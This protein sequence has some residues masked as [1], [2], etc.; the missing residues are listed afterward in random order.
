MIL[1][2]ETFADLDTRTLY[3]LLRLRGD[4]FVVEQHCPYPDLDGRD[5]EPG[6][7]HLWFAP[8]GNPFEPHAYLRILAE[9][10]GVLRIGRVCSDQKERGAGLSGRLMSAALTRSA[11]F[12]LDA[13]SYL[14]PFYERFGFVAAGP[15]YVEDGIA[16][17]PMR[18]G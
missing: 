6:T 10:D 3:A 16:H 12:V 4:V 17:T 18:R 14:V 9:A 15:Q 8:E 7:R 1:H 5:T 13:Q 2:E 11:P